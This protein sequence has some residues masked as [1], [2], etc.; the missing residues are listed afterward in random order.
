MSVNGKSVQLP[1]QHFR[2]STASSVFWTEAS[3]QMT[4]SPRSLF[5]PSPQLLST[6]SP[7][8]RF[9]PGVTPNN[10]LVTGESE[11]CLQTGQCR[12]PGRKALGWRNY[13]PDLWLRHGSGDWEREVAD[14]N[15]IS[16]LEKELKSAKNALLEKDKFVQELQKIII[17]IETDLKETK[18]ART[19]LIHENQ[20]LVIQLRQTET[21]LKDQV[22]TA[23]QRLSSLL[24]DSFRKL[25]SLTKSLPAPNL[26]FKDSQEFCAFLLEENRKLT[27]DLETAKKGLKE[28]FIGILEPLVCELAAIRRDIVQ[29]GTL[30]KGARAGEHLRLDVLWGVQ[31]T[32]ESG[33][34]PTSYS[35]ACMQEV[36]SIK[37]SVAD[38]K[39]IAADLYAE[40]CGQSC[41]PQ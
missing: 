1:A 37:E 34:R 8:S 24:A 27:E 16:D 36:T 40:Q 38:M 2:S 31:K 11:D 20:S 41:A 26:S 5:T 33:A 32:S 4:V 15:R 30:L 35:L 9:H 21:T 12:E 29:L 18:A 3:T 23:I 25:K 14:F 17:N 6:E 7:Q 19:V 10:S 39:K 13:G 22:N 28:G